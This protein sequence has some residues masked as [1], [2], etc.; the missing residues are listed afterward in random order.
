MK[1]LLIEDEQQL[2]DSII[3]YLSGEHY[4]CEHAKSYQQAYEKIHL[5]EYECILLDLMLPGGNGI[6]LLE[7]IKEENKD[8]GVIIISARDAIDDKIK[9]LQTGADDY[10][11]KPFH[12]SEL[13]ARIYSVIRRRKFQNS[14]IIEQ[15][16]LKLDLLAKKV[17]VHQQEVF[18][19]RKEFDLLMYFLGNQNR[20]L[21]K[22]ALAEHLSGDIADMLDDHNFVYAHIK[23]LKRKLS[24]AGC[25]N[26]LKTIYGTGYKWEI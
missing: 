18:L 13:S 10:L 19:T 12:L 14:N 3:R 22:N 9:G 25:D 23:N 2:A 11:A 5:Y 6:K 1:V 8:T 4:L 16:E 26:Y 7:Q 17:Q 24:E 21:S 15:N 20:V